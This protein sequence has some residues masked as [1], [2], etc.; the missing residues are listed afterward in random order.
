MRRPQAR[1]DMRDDR[2]AMMRALCAHMRDMQNR[3][4]RNMR[5]C[6]ITDIEIN[7]E[8]KSAQNQRN[9]SIFDDATKYVAIYRRSSS[10]LITLLR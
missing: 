1:R 9:R 6:V 3:V 2:C 4:P 7:G 8:T 10:L 5:D